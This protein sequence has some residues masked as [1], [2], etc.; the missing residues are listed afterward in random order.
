LQSHDFIGEL[1]FTL[2]EVVTTRDQTLTKPLVNPKVAK[3]GRIKIHGE[4]MAATSNQELIM[5]TPEASNLKDMSGQIFFIIY[6]NLAPANYT[7]IYKSETKAAAGGR[8]VWN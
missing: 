3:P 5:F 8:L 2:H 1:L 6:K 7:P 4:E